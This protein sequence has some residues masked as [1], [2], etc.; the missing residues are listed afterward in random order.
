MTHKSR[1]DAYVAH[2]DSLLVTE[3]TTPTA[4]GVVKSSRDKSAD[5][6]HISGRLID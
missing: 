1:A 3:V 6:S 2:N 4:A 5:S